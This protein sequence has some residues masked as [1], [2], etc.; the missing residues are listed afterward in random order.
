[1]DNYKQYFYK[2][3]R[4]AQIRG[5]YYTAQHK[6]IISEA[7]K[8]LGLSQSTVS[9]Q[10]QTLERDLQ[11]KLF[12]REDRPY[13]LTEAGRKFYQKIAP[14]YQKFTGLYEEFI[15]EYQQE[16]L[17]KIIIASNHRCILYVLPN[18]IKKYQEICPDIEITIENTI[19]DEALERLTRGEIHIGIFPLKVIPPECVF[20][21]ITSYNPILIINKNHPLAMKE[22]VT[23][24]DVSPY[25]FIRIDPGLITFPSFEEILRRHHLTSHITFIGADWEILKKFVEANAAIAI[26]SDMCFGEHDNEKLVVRPLDNYFPKMEYGAFIRNGDYV[27]PALEKLI[28]VIKAYKNE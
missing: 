12:N 21:P 15:I 28:E 13:T 20:I 10:I 5:F 11:V 16:Q 26:I 18:I 2:D 22:V 9:T 25:Q 6:N 7:A 14:L 17:N 27:F 19:R 4:L 1:M 3:N 24:E 23:L 8:A